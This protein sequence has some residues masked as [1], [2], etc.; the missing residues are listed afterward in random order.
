M[1]TTRV[2][3][4]LAFVLTAIAPQQL[5]AASPQQVPNKYG[6]H[7]LPQATQERLLVEPLKPVVSG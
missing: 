2:L 1:K 4:F 5:A 7:A 3:A 6:K